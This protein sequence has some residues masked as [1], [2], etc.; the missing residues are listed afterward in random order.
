MTEEYQP[1]T[2]ELERQAAAKEHADESSP[3]VD[4]TD[5]NGNPLGNPKDGAVADVD[6]PGGDEPDPSGD[7]DE[8]EEVIAP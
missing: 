1:T 7:E 5:E 4:Q 2:E 8:D 6:E 3:R